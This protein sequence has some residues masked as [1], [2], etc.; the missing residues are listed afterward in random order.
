MFKFTS[1]NFTIKEREIINDFLNWDNDYKNKSIFDIVSYSIEYCLLVSNNKNSFQLQYLKNKSFYLDTNIIYRALGINGET[2]KKRTETFLRRCSETNIKLF[3]SKYNEKEFID[4]IKYYITRMKAYGGRR[5]SP[6]LF[7]RYSDNYDIYDFYYKWREKRSSTNFNIFH[8]Y[9]LALYDKFKKKNNISVDYKIPYNEK[10]KD[11]M[12]IIT[13]YSE[14][15][16]NL[17]KHSEDTDV[18]DSCVMDAKNIFHLEQKRDSHYLNLS[19]TKFFFIS[20]DQMLRKW[21][22]LRS[23]YVPIVLHPSQ[24]LSIILRFI[25]RSVD[26]YKSY[27]SFLN[28][29]QVDSHFDNERL[30]IVFSA[31]SELTEDFKTQ[32][33]LVESIIQSHF[34]NILDKKYSNEEVYDKTKEFVKSTLENRIDEVE[35]RNLELSSKLDEL[36]KEETTVKIDTKID[37][38]SD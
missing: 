20:N 15:I 36:K 21:D 1:T 14:E 5:V 12:S 22:F 7:S 31:I 35:K 13:S 6:K 29:R 26:D 11:V 17:K 32:E 30:F 10:S 9:I 24:W 38:I 4:S 33:E 19:D 34:N 16:F 23:D 8:N 25:S 27:I 2:R 28:L 37:E 3:I 18:N